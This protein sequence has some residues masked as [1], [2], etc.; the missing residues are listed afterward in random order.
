MQDV[1]GNWRHAYEEALKQFQRQPNPYR[2]AENTGAAF[3]PEPGGKQG[4]FSLSYCGEEYVISYPEGRIYPAG[5]PQGEVPPSVQTCILLYMAQAVPIPR[6][7]GWKTFKDLPQGYHHWAPFVLEA[8][9]PLVKGF[10]ND[11]AALARA[12]QALGGRPVAAGDAGYE[13]AVLPR[14]DLQVI[15]WAGDDEFP[16]KAN[17]LFNETCVMQLDTATLYMIGIHLS[18]RLLHQAGKLHPGAS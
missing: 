9:D 14:I 15:M 13:F 12:A 10:G 4:R 5:D 6:G 2:V 17:I 16:P 7:Q 8:L 18:R 11:L 3:Q 1:P